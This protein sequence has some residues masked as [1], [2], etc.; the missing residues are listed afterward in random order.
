MDLQVTWFASAKKINSN[1]THPSQNDSA[2]TFEL[3][4]VAVDVVPP[5]AKRKG[6]ILVLPGWNF[7]RRLWLD[8][9]NLKE[10]AS[11]QGYTL[12]LPEMMRSVYASKYYPET[13]PD[14]K[15]QPTL[16]WLTDTLIP[17]LQKKYHLFTYKKKLLLGLSTGARGVVRVAEQTGNFFDAGVALSGDYDQTLFTQDRLMEAVYGKYNSYPEIWKSLW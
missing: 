4:S 3:D 17:F 11:I 8:S 15:K 12:V 16:I 5:K 6:D 2:F 1:Q 9:T 10:F 13:S 14:M 7:S